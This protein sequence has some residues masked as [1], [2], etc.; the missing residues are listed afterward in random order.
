MLGQIGG[1]KLVVAGLWAGMA[2][3][4]EMGSEEMGSVLTDSQ[5]SR[6]FRCSEKW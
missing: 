2:A 4:E 3:R 1:K 6:P 5:N